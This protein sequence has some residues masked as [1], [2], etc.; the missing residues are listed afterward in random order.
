MSKL[1]EYHAKHML[2][3]RLLQTVLCACFLFILLEQHGICQTKEPAYKRHAK[4]IENL[5]HPVARHV[6]EWN[7]LTGAREFTDSTKQYKIRAQVIGFTEENI[8]LRKVVGGN[9]VIVPLAKLDPSHSKEVARL[10]VLEKQIPSEVARYKEIHEELKKNTV[11]S[12]GMDGLV[13]EIKQYKIPVKDIIQLNEIPSKITPEHAG[14]MVIIE[15]RYK[16]LN[17]HSNVDKETHFSFEQSLPSK[18]TNGKHITWRL[19][20][21]SSL[22]STY[23]EAY[24]TSD[25]KIAYKPTNKWG[26]YTRRLLMSRTLDAGKT[27]AFLKARGDDAPQLREEF[28]FEKL[29]K[30]AA[31]YEDAGL[32]FNPLS[33]FKEGQSKSPLYAYSDRTDKFVHNGFAYEVSMPKEL[34]FKGKRQGDYGLKFRYKITGSRGMDRNQALKKIL[35]ERGRTAF[36]KA[37]DD[38]VYNGVPIPGVGNGA[39][40]PSPIRVFL[41]AYV[42]KPVKQ[43]LVIHPSGQT[44]KQFKNDDVSLINYD[45]EHFKYQR[46]TR[47]NDLSIRDVLP[48]SDSTSYPRLSI[49]E[50]VFNLTPSSS[51]SKKVREALLKEE[52][53]A[54]EGI[55]VLRRY[56]AKRELCGK[57]GAYTIDAGENVHDMEVIRLYIQKWSV[58]GTVTRH[59]GHHWTISDDKTILLDV[60]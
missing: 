17:L 55:D 14:K 53:R 43:R 57:V 45:S 50:N 59:D 22:S 31:Q 29:E 35:E 10:I 58:P 21:D 47:S 6:K 5:N 56:E 41:H 2:R 28:D 3:F 15:A 46:W 25:D 19:F 24:I 48:S 23:Y 7:K 40:S 8:T 4:E 34:F 54:P 52:E 38:L 42:G 60:R 32:D 44:D 39:T 51:S 26:L 13:E 20:D 16:D 1:L 12:R 18:W 33:P 37:V 11:K 36:N 27:I 9:A 49:G 30:K